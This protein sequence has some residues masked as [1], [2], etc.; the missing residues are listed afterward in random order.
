MKKLKVNK[1]LLSEKSLRSYDLPDYYYDETINCETCHKS[2]VFT[3]EEQQEWYEV[4]RKYF[5]MRPKY[6]DTHYNEWLARYKSKIEMDKMFKELEQNDSLKVIFKVAESIYKYYLLNSHQGNI[7]KLRQLLKRC[8]ENKHKLKQSE[9]I[10]DH[11]NAIENN[12]A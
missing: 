2:F 4:Q 9:K 3:K 7:E 10:L 5:W 11:I 1:N 12:K 8:I 6:C